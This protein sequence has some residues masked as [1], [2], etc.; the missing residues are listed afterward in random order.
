MISRTYANDF[1]LDGIPM[2]APAYIERILSIR[3]A[4][5]RK[6]GHFDYGNNVL[7]VIKHYA[8]LKD[9]TER[10]QFQGALEFMLQSNN[11]EWRNYAVT[12]CLGFFA[13]RDAV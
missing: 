1:T 9:E 11:T 13:F 4:G 5:L 3:D 6:V 12:L 8:T 7:P 2:D 10:K